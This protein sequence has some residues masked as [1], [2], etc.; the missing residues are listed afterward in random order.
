MRMAMALVAG[1]VMAGCTYRGVEAPSLS[2]RDSEW[3]ALVPPFEYHTTHLPWDMPDPTGEKP[4]TVVVDTKDNYLYIVQPGGRALRYAVAT[5]SEAFGWTGTATVQRKAEWP[6]WTPPPE[7]LRRWPHLAG[8]AG[9]MAGGPD[10]P[11]GARALY[12]YQNG[13]D[14]MYRIHGTN[15]PET[16]GHG[17]SSGCIRMRNI[18]VVDVFNKVP[19]GTKV[20]V[21]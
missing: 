17:A 14:T 1:L 9:G 2:A 6:R 8:R 15:E 12:L 4:G 3:I 10:N 19:V 5:G 21:R 20:I 13:R 16:I 7:M 18:D 11:L